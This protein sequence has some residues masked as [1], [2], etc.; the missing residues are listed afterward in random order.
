MERLGLALRFEDP[1]L[2]YRWVEPDVIDYSLAHHD[3]AHSCLATEKRH[4]VGS[5]ADDGEVA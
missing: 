1:V 4:R 5:V 3:L 2:E